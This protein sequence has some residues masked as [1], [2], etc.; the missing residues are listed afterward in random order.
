MLSIKQIKDNSEELRRLGAR[1][2]ETVLQRGRSEAHKAEWER[3]CAEWH[4]R[5]DRLSFPGGS[6]LL[7]RVR[8]N[9]ASA[10]EAAVRFLVADPYHFRSGYLKQELWRWLAHCDLA[11]S[12]RNR[13][14]Q[15][16]LSYLDRRISREF[17][18]MCKAMARLGSSQFWLKVSLKAQAADGPEATR[19]LYLLSHGADVHA[20]ARVRRSVY[21][22]YIE[23][24][25]G[26]G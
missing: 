5:F 14:E 7:D 4:A 6:E 1:V 16:A 8:E 23:R 15:A 10:V 22:E 18:T 24:K 21:R 19:A 12:A 25:F 3:A 20:G 17:W 11:T 2:Q 9:D 26:G 13:L